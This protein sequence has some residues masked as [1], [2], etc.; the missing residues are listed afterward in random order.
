MVHWALFGCFLIFL[1]RIPSF[2]EPAWHTD[3][4]S[5]A[6]V[7]EGILRGRDLYSEAWESKPPLFLYLY[8]GIFKVFGSGL[9]QLKIAAAIAAISTQFAIF[10]V[11]TKLAG[12]VRGLTASVVF[13]V[14]VAVP[15]W[16]G[17]LALSEIFSMPAATL[18]VLVVL[19]RSD[20]GRPNADAWLALAG[21]L[22]G[23]AFLL[24]QPAV[25]AMP[26]AV[27]WLFLDS[28]LTLSRLAVL[29]AGFA[30][31]IV[32]IT[33]AFA[34]FGSFFW[35]WDANVAYFLYYV[36]NGSRITST[37]MLYMFAPAA[38]ALVTLVWLRMRGAPTPAWALP[39]LWFALAF[40]GSLL[41]GKDYSHYLLQTFPALA[42]LLATLPPPWLRAFRVTLRQPAFAV[43][44][45]F[46]VAWYVVVSA[47]FYDPWGRHWTKG[48]AYYT[49]F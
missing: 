14:L 45:T 28:R 30:L 2:F 31:P 48:P 25:L 36:P 35:F 15:F 39:A 19:A 49:H 5:F 24:R 32:V 42:L 37:L 20:R 21:V 40:I 26:A 23:L 7:A 46:A 22:F 18:G 43:A 8:A 29:A 27:L 16:E 10:L 12:P 38:V 34:V 13:G 41:N 33:A 3:E 1:L 17:N 9:L 44:V 4:G 47:V 6:G 11:G